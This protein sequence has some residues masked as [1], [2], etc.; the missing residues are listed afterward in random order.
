[1]TYTT[2]ET[3]TVPERSM[4]MI[5]GAGAPESP[6]FG[7]AVG[8]LFATRAALGG[9]DVPL[10]GTYWQRDGGFGFDRPDDWLWILAV[11]APD[12]VQSLEGSLGADG[13]RL[14]HQPL[15][16]VV[17]AVHHGPYVEETA[18]LAALR[19]DAAARGLTIT[20]PHTERYLTDPR[21]TPPEQLRTLLWYPVNS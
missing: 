8:A 12:G 10:E 9:G 1:M 15:T 4:L 14:D 11:P 6:A 19:A 2:M 13:V 16:R 7:A 17:Q 21:S 5:D 3:A 20:G 18:T